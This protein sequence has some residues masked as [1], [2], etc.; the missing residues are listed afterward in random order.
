M[1]SVDETALFD[2]MLDE[3]PVGAYSRSWT[4]PRDSEEERVE[5]AERARRRHRRRHG[6]GRGG[7]SGSGS[8]RGSSTDDDAPR[9]QLRLP[10]FSVRWR[11][12]VVGG[13]DTQRGRR[14]SDV[15]RGGGRDGPGGG[16]GELVY[17]P[18]DEH[19]AY[20]EAMRCKPVAKHLELQARNL[21]SSR[22][23]KAREHDTHGTM[24]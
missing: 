5:M 22:T 10:G 20:D 14:D 21:Y 23:T 2:R 11:M 18:V 24:G 12:Q 15:G 3:R 13:V 9:T 6:R 7:G 19:A 8:G 1:S 17:P 16:G 4:M